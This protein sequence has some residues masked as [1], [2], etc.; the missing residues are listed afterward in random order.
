MLSTNEI[1][2]QLDYA[3]MK[4]K[5]GDE[6]KNRLLESGCVSHDESAVWLVDYW[7]DKDVY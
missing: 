1:M 6:D 4:K 5:F 7:C 2:L 3:E